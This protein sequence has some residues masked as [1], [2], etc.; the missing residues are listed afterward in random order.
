MDQTQAPLSVT[1]ILTALFPETLEIQESVLAEETAGQAGL[2]HLAPVRDLLP[3]VLHRV[4]ARDPKACRAVDRLS[5]ASRDHLRVLQALTPPV[6]VRLQEDL[7]E[8][9]RT[10]EE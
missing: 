10:R 2:E 8:A 5:Q 4:Q 9:H 6:R 3:E 7:R 1:V